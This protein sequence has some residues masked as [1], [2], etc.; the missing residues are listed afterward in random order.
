[1]LLPRLFR[2]VQGAVGFSKV[3][4]QLQIRNLLVRTGSRVGDGE[5][6]V[7][8][9]VQTTA[10]L[11]DLTSDYKSSKPWVM[12]KQKLLRLHLFLT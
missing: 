11:A 3:L 10:V 4:E 8:I 1:M 7:L 9:Q 6:R 2:Q 12:E 5:P